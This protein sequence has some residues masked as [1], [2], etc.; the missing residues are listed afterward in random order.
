MSL[1]VLFARKMSL[2]N[3]INDYNYKLM[4]KKQELMDLQQ[5]TAAI[6]DGQVS[7]NDLSTA[8][9]SVFG[10]MSQYMVASH[11]YAANAAQQNMAYL[12]GS[13]QMQPISTDGAAQAQYQQLVF[14]NLYNQQ[15]DQFRKAEE[16]RLNVKNKALDNECLKIEQQLKQLET[17]YQTLGSAVDKYAKES[18]PQYA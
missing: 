18:A 16:A 11:N 15:Q 4:Q 13:G 6:A 12:Q 17:E 9:S 5:Y 14:Q 3:Q 8:P 10:R 2:K 1:L 7:L